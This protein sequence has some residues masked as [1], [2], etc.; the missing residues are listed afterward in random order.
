MA[1]APPRSKAYLLKSRNNSWWVNVDLELTDSS[2]RCIASEYAKWV[3]QELGLTDYKAKLSAGEEVVIFDFPRDAAT[4][5][6]L[7][8][9][10]RGGCEVSYGD[11]RRWIVSLVYPS[12]FGS[13]LDLMTDR[14]IWRQ[15]R[16]E[17]PGNAVKL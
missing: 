6:W 14:A 2:V 12:G 10:Y 5:T 11:S 1:S 3:D 4:V 9:F 17:L 7:G 16:E 8:Q 15:W 13:V